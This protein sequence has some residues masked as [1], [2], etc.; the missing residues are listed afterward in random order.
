MCDMFR[1]V[2]LPL[3]VFFAI[4]PPQLQAQ[5][6]PKTNSGCGVSFEREEK[7]PSR[8]NNEAKAC[9][10]DIALH[11]QRDPDITVV[12]VGNTTA[13]ESGLP[14]LAAR[15]AVNVKDYLVTEK[16]LDSARVQARTSTAQAK[17]ADIYFVPSG[18]EL[19]WTYQERS[20]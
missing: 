2:A 10:D 5:L 11:A 4:P 18:A 20:M 13:G 17:S 12:V 19:I 1:V 8:V 7:R 3:L 15:R 6:S 14:N 9:L 16:G